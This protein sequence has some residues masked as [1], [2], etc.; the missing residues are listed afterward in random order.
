[1]LRQYDQSHNEDGF[2]LMELMVALV[3]M[4]LVGI[5]AWRGMDAMIRGREI[6]DQNANRDARTT[7]LI[8]QFER[9]CQQMLRPGELNIPTN[10]NAAGAGNP[11]IGS[12]A[13]ST[14]AAGAKNIWWIRYYRS[15]NKDAWLIV[16]Y[17]VV[18]QGLQRW[19]SSPLFRR[20]EANTLWNTIS[21]DPD[22]NSSDFLLSFEDPEIVRQKFL[23]QTSILNGAGGVGVSASGTAASAT[24]SNTNLT[25][26]SNLSPAQQGVTMQWWIKDM[27]IPIS[28]SC[29]MGGAL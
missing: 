6:I 13:K 5:M 28:R 27:T 16:G 11:A 14:I 1:M 26:L 4:A 19:T 8:R 12:T 15:N 18:P 23:V 10:N 2:A 7:Q 9:D 3:I 25:T 29:L 22:L 17:G 20:V 24:N 21:A